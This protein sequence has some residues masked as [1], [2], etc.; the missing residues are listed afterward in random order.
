[1]KDGQTPAQAQ[2][3]MMKQGDMTG[4]WVWKSNERS[5]WKP[6]DSEPDAAFIQGFPAAL[7][8]QWQCPWVC[9]GAPGPEEGRGLGTL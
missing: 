4:V 1:M 6:Q 7:A 8:W 9:M 3:Q 5:F 2:I